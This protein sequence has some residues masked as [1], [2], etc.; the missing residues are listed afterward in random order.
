MNP[1]FKMGQG[2]APG[3][4]S[5]GHGH[6]AGITMQGQVIGNS[7]NTSTNITGLSHPSTAT[8]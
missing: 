8:H 4:G 2:M 6:H 7:A 5:A 3:A 1:L